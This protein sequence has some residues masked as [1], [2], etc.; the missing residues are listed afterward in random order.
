MVSFQNGVENEDTLRQLAGRENVIA[1]TVTSA[2][3]RRGAGDIIVEK[4]R[5]VGIC[6]ENPAAN[7]LAD[8]LRHCGIKTTTYSD[9]KSMKWSKMLTNIPANAIAAILHMTAAEVYMHPAAFHMEVEM[10]REALRVMESLKIPVSD[11]PGTPVR[12]MAW[13]FDKLPTG[14]SRPLLKQGI[15]KGRGGKMPSFYLDLQSGKNQSEVEFLNGAIARIGKRYQVHVPINSY[16][17]ETLMALVRGE[18]PLD[19]YLRNPEKL[20]A[21]ISLPR[22]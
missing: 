20:R 7:R 4:E 2:I 15:G 3:G 1:A 9:E 14:L 5:G 16:I 12:L 22:P 19:T 8:A 21:G 18:L 6:I 10:F 13:L 17:T 11:L